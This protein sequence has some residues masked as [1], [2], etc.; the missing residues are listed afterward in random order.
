MKEH[1]LYFQVNKKGKTLNRQEI[2]SL[3]SSI[4]NP[5]ELASPFTLDRRIIR[6]LFH[7]KSDWNEQIS[8]NMA[9]NAPKFLW[10]TE[11]S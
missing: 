5:L 4:Y 2:L 8:D 7:K 11:S 3:L 1:W 6:N 9:R 10:E